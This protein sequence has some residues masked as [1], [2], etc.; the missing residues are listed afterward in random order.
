MFQTI[1]DLKIPIIVF[2][3]VALHS[4]SVNVVFFIKCIELSQAKN[5]N[6]TTINTDLAM[7]RKGQYIDWIL[8]SI[9][10]FF[11]FFVNTNQ[12]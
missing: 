11:L 12:A 4:K 10:V 7:F 6:Q 8:I 5:I 9:S 1:F 3:I 2:V